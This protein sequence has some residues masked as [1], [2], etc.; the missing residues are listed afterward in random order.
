[1]FRNKIFPPEKNVNN[2]PIVFLNNLPINIKS[3]EK[4]LRLL[5]DG[6]RNFSEHINE[7]FKEVT[8][9][10]NVLGKLNLSLSLSLK[11]KSLKS[12]E[13]LKDRQRMRKL[14]Y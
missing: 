7:K 8:K 4:H 10:N 6:K 13:S 9:S 2:H 1:M 14:C 3:T 12:F 5:L 11:Q